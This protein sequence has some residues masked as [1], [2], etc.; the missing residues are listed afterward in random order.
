MRYEIRY[1]ACELSEQ[2]PSR[3]LGQQQK[4]RGAAVFLFGAE[5]CC[6]FN[7]SSLLVRDT[8]TVFAQPEVHH[9]T[10]VRQK[11]AGGHSVVA[12]SIRRKE[13]LQRC[14]GA[15]MHLRKVTQFSTICSASSPHVASGTTVGAQILRLK[16]LRVTVS[17]PADRK[18][19]IKSWIG[20][21][22]LKKNM[23]VKQPLE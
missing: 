16:C 21:L 9:S 4:K 15:K 12:N 22:R 6:T 20:A 14:K 1:A 23:H 7:V 11:N 18:Q 8:A 17:H 19:R 10:T 2:I 3:H 13:H 5:L